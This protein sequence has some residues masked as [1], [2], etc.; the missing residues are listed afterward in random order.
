MNKCKLPPPGWHCTQ[1]AGHEG[2]C[3]AIE[4]GS[5]LERCVDKVEHYGLRIIRYFNN[6]NRIKKCHS[7][8]AFDTDSECWSATCSTTGSRIWTKRIKDAELMHVSEFGGYRRGKTVDP[9]KLLRM[10][11]WTDV[12]LYTEEEWKEQIKEEILNAVFKDI[13]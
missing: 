8:Y 11:G 1:P 2:P 10:E 4:N 7:V 6:R 9:M 5:F 12:W 13:E 3:A